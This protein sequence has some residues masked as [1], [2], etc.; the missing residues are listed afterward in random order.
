MSDWDNLP[1]INL[2][3][4]KSGSAKKIR[5][6]NHLHKIVSQRVNQ[7]PKWKRQLRSSKANNSK[8]KPVGA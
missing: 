7:I 1:E 8:S 5:H 4:T 3:T 6:A 2:R